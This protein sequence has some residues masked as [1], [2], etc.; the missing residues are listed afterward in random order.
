MNTSYLSSRCNPANYYFTGLLLGILLSLCGCATQG[1]GAANNFDPYEN[2]NRKIYT[3]NDKVDDYVAKPVSDAYQ[4]ITPQFMQ[5]GVYNFFNNLKNIN[6][7]LNDVLQAKFGQSAHDTGR[8]LMNTTLGMAGLFDVAKT[9]GLEANDEDF[10]QTL[11]V[12]GVPQGTY[13]VLPLLG[14]ITT[15]GIPGAVFDTAAN[16]AN[17]VG[18][19]VQVISLI[20]TRAN[21]EGSLKFID[22]AALDPY[23]FTRESF[24]Q[25]RNHLATDGKESKSSDLSDLD[26]DLMADDKNTAPQPAAAKNAPTTSPTMDVGKAVEKTSAA[27]AAP[28][29]Q[30]IDPS[31]KK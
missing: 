18:V 31:A 23:V 11:A 6:V 29:A 9:V 28:A 27:T 5:T 17:Y 7:V 14:P 2:I 16:P 4:F 12:W 21:A 30:S 26:A 19:P 24:L 8:F 22:E 3:F 25:W 20:N 13:L 1:T 10:E 15:R